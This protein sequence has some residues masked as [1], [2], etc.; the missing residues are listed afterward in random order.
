MITETQRDP[1]F[2]RKF[3]F[4]SDV[5]A[6]CGKNPYKTAFDV[7]LEKNGLKELD[8][9]SDNDKVQA[10]NFMER[11][12]IDFFEYKNKLKTISPTDTFT[13]PNYE[14]IKCHLDALVVSGEP[15]FLGD[16]AVVT[17]SPR[18]VLE[19]KCVDINTKA[20]WDERVPVP[21]LLQ[22]TAQMAITGLHKGYLAAYMGGD[23]LT[24]HIFAVN[25]QLEARMLAR[26]VEF[27]NVCML[28]KIPPQAATS[29]DALQMYPQSTAKEIKV[30][31]GLK[32]A[33]ADFNAAKDRIDYY[34]EKKK[35]ARDVI[36]SYMGEHDK[37]V[38]HDGTVLVTWRNDK[39]SMKFDE[40]AFELH[41]KAT[42]LQFMKERP[43]ARKLLVKGSKK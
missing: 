37:L 38:D 9:L 29:E 1:A 13:H 20:Q 4:A 35:A 42:H 10:G 23:R 34:E 32:L 7:Y 2:R 25:K 3:I 33:V 21:Y 26:L 19:V 31:D 22:L 43:G 14:F 18:A 40:K 27:Y 17:V 5:A 6:I 8:D 16:T 11:G 30:T 15:D 12:I 39:S 41:D 28:N 24:T 36:C